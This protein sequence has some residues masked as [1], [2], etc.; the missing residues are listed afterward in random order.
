MVYKRGGLE[1]SHSGWRLGSTRHAGFVV[2][3][4]WGGKEP[5]LTK[6][7]RPNRLRQEV[8]GANSVPRIVEVAE[9]E[10]RSTRP[11]KSGT[12]GK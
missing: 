9:C 1:L 3:P 4:L 6:L 12:G 5:G 7:A 2:Q 8:G 10:S 11:E